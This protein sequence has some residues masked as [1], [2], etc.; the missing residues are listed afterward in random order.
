VR[1][2]HDIPENHLLEIACG[3]PV[4]VKKDIVAV[5]RKMLEYRQCPGKNWCGGN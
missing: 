5:L 3:N 4:V 1:P 2:R